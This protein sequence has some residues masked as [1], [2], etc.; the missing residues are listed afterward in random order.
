MNK[1]PVKLKICTEC[2]KG[3]PSLWKTRTL[4]GK[5]QSFCQAC[6]AKVEKKDVKEKKEKQKQRRKEKRERITERKL[7]AVTSRLIRSIYPLICHGC[8][9]QLE[10]STAQS[11]HFV[12]RKA[13]SVRFSIMNQLPVC[14]QCNFFD[15]SHVYSL[16]N[17]LNIYWGEGTAEDI[18]LL[19]KK[20]MQITQLMRNELYEL[21]SNP[22][23][24]STE[25]ETRKLILEKY[26]EIFK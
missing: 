19:G 17:W 25:E 8:N 10:F 21:Y 14:K 26:L 3:F 2:K 20:T 15:Q 9:K 16:G 7:D 18:R 23:K 22:P 13:R 6:W 11:G 4:N 5:K 1:K 12:S 24:G